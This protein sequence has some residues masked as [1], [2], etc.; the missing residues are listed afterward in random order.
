MAY[1]LLQRILNKTKYYAAIGLIVEGVLNRTISDIL[2]LPDIPEV[3]SHRLCELC[4]IFN[5]L[6]GLFV[7]DASQEASMADITYLFEEGALVDFHVDELVR[8]VRA[9]FADTQLRTNTIIKL[10]VGHPA[11]RE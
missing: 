7:E 11:P 4:H 9:L 6:E 5:A 1:V 8:L 10:S 2:A 3:E